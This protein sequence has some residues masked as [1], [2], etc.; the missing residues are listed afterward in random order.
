MQRS[1]DQNTTYHQ[2]RAVVI[3]KL[4]ASCPGVAMVPLFYRQL[5]KEKTAALKFHYGNFD[6]SMALS[7][8][9]E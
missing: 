6:E 1:F 8:K 9:A 3:G 5:K 4:V 7:P 2:G